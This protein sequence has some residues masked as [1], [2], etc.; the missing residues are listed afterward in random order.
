MDRT[1]LDALGLYGATFVACAAGAVVPVF[2]SEVYLLAVGA[3]ASPAQLPLLATLAATGQMA[4]K[5]LLYLGGRGA[6]RW[7]VRSPAV[8]GWRER[9]RA[10]GRAGSLL[11]LASAVTGVP[12]FY[13]LS[14]AAGA[15]SWSFPRFLAT[16]T[17]GRLLR[18]G[19][20]LAL[21]SLA[22]AVHR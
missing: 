9:L 11:L 17:A 13:A 1:I 7:P 6:L 3:I 8:D 2:N 10:G 20:L 14:V 22:R 15:V 16:G 5:S 19:A 4:G 12:P 18:F 21:P